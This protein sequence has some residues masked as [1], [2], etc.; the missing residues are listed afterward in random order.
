MIFFLVK[1]RFSGPPPF[2]NISFFGISVSINVAGIGTTYNVI[3]GG[4]FNSEF[5][6]NTVLSFCMPHIFAFFLRTGK[7][8]FRIVTVLT[9]LYQFV[10]QLQHMFVEVPPSCGCNLKLTFY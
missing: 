3:S 7:L 9:A 10:Q 4:D 2:F 5:E 1:T 8:V 6:S